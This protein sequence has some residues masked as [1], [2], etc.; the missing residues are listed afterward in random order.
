MHL[1]P[2]DPNGHSALVVMCALQNK[3]VI[4][5]HAPAVIVHSSEQGAHYESETTGS[6]VADGL[7][8]PFL[9]H[10]YCICRLKPNQ[11]VNQK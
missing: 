11:I 9:V 3:A 5:R 8:Q 6:L 7:P 10:R 2:H 4:D 1:L